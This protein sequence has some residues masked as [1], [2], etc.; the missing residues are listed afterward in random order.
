VDNL[1]GYIGAVIDID[2]T[3]YRLAGLDWPDALLADPDADGGIGA[4]VRFVRRHV[5]DVAE[6]MVLIVRNP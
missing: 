1:D 2:G 5:D 4:P 3:R 6:A